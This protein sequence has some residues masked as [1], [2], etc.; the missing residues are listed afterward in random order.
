MPIGNAEILDAASARKPE[1]FSTLI[2]HSYANG[3][4]VKNCRRPSKCA[5]TEEG[6]SRSRPLYIN[7]FHSCP[8][9]LDQSI[10]KVS[11]R[12]VFTPS[13]QLPFLQY[14]GCRWTIPLAEFID[15]N[16]ENLEQIVEI[17]YFIVQLARAG[18]LRSNNMRALPV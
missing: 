15:N 18:T 12:S 8:S 9:V 10:I 4:E 6:I 14:S 7:I 5:A 17:R 3:K 13:H 16:Q 1:D 2:T 11:W